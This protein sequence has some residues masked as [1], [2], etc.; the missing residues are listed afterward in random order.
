M[1]LSSPAS[2]RLF[3]QRVDDLRLLLER[4]ATWM[5]PDVPH[6]PLRIDDRQMRDPVY[7]EPR[8]DN[9]ARG[10]GDVQDLTA[11]LSRPSLFAGPFS[12]MR[13]S[14]VGTSTLGQECRA[15]F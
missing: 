2:L 7:I 13:Q 14:K 8:I 10:E 5:Q 11:T 9:T 3:E 15:E 1:T 6:V 4:S 12:K